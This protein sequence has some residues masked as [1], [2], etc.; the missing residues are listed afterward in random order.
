MYARYKASRFGIEDE[1]G[2][3][4]SCAENSGKIALA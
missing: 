4:D 2:E 3:E 1:E